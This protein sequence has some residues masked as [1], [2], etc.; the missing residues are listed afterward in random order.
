MMAGM[1]TLIIIG[2]LRGIKTHR[3]LV[4][5]NLALRN[6]L[7][8]LQRAARRPCLRR[9]DRLFWVLL[10]RLW[11]GWADALSLV[12]PE[13]VIRWHRTSF[14][15]LWTW[16]SWQRGPAARRSLR[17]SERSSAGWPRPT[18][19]GAR[20]A[21]TGSSGSSASRSA[22]RRSRSTWSASS[23][24]PVSDLALSRCLRARQRNASDEFLLPTLLGAAFDAG[25]VDAAQALFEEIRL[26]HVQMEARNDDP[27]SGAEPASLDRR[28]RAG[29]PARDRGPIEATGLTREGIHELHDK[30][31]RSASG[32]GWGTEA[33]PRTR[34]RWVA[35]HPESRVAPEDRE[36]S[37]RPAIEATPTF[38]CVT[39]STCRPAPPQARSSPRRSRSAGRLKSS[40]RS[41]WISARSSSRRACCGRACCGPSTTRSS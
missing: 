39:T 5:E 35:R 1:I 29:S 40:G 10:S 3:A 36:H 32:E 38:A 41:T 34:R 25:D 13:T 21:F 30:N 28:R 8:V 18:P 27:G 23:N 14:K 2:L 7:A 26:R 31:S 17:S 9:S 22:R 15:L 11:S 20:P 37:P 4:L 33:Y 19:Y 24:A 6:Q 16:K 12:K